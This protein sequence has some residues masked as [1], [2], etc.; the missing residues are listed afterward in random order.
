[1]EQKLRLVQ[2]VR[3]RYQENQFDMSNRERIL[4]GKTT[5]LPESEYLSPYKEMYEYPAESTGGAGSSFKLRFLAA[6][7]LLG[8]VI[9]M[10]KNGIK[11]AGIT[12]KEIFQ[13]ISAD[14]DQKVEE[15]L[16]AFSYQT[17]QR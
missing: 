9:L 13:A 12:T 7:I 10:D 6:V 14:Y 3:S 5:R 15:W 4:Y 16:E 2:Q 8:A 11:V 17:P 1:M